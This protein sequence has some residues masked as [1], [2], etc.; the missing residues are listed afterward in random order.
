M[1]D[2]KYIYLG[3]LALNTD[4]EDQMTLLELMRTTH[5]I[6]VKAQLEW[7]FPDDKDLTPDYK[8]LFYTMRS[9]KP[10]ANPMR[11]SLV[12][13]EPS[14]FNECTAID[15]VGRNGRRRRDEEQYFP[16]GNDGKM[17]HAD[18]EVQWS[19]SFEPRE[20]WLGMQVDAITLQQFLP[21]QII[22]Y[23]L[24]DLTFYG[25]DEADVVDFRDELNRRVEEIDAMTEEELKEKLVPAEVAFADLREILKVVDGEEQK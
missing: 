24:S 2:V 3:C 16:R 12:T 1:R 7:V 14:E 25:F 11:I 10:E 19:L 18:E 20:K 4:G 23:C 8:N 21:A 22:A 13:I 17:D 5:W 9:M 6:E 15:V